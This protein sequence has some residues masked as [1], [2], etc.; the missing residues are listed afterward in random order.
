MLDL[1]IRGGTVID[2]TGA[3]RFQADIGI[4]GGQIVT[5]GETD[6]QADHEIDAQGLLVTPGWVDVH[7]HYDGQVTWDPYLTPSIWHGV[8]TVVMG[9][10]GVGFAPAAPDQHDWLISLMEGVEDI[11]GTA[12][13]EGIQWQ[14]ESFPEYM[15]SIERGSISIDV[16]AQVP[17]GALRAFVMGERGADHQTEPTTEEIETM[18]RLAREAIAA[19]AVGFSSSRTRN[20]RTKDGDYT[21]SLTASPAEMLGIAKA[22]GEGGRGVFEMVADFAHLD[23]E[24]ALLREMVEVSGRPMSISVAQN[25][26]VPNQWRRLLDLIGEAVNEGLPMTAQV[27]PR[28]IGLLLGLQASFHPFMTSRHYKGIEALPLSERVERMRDPSLKAKILADEI[29]PGLAELTCRFERIF[30]LGDPPDYEPAPEDSM[31]ARAE[32]DDITPRDLV[33]DLLLKNEGHALLYRTFLNYTDYNLDVSRDM[34]LDPNTVPG[35]GDAGA[36]CGLICD[37]SFPSFLMLHFGRDR[38]RGEKL[39]LEWLVKRQTAD[40][41]RLIG[42]EDRG[43]IQPGKRADL[44]LIDWSAMQLRPPEILFDLPAGGKRLV[45]RVD[46]YRMTL[47]AGQSVCEDGKPTGI[48]PGQLVRHASAS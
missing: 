45:Q 9:N 46:G 36:H 18:G 33:Y 23:E 44:N 34:L 40:T 14:W 38:T 15:D 30:E 39:E 11:P 37:G 21:P 22:I 10:C 12:L 24:F 26:R 20:H 42:L 8:T 2:G 4:R 6:E 25:D 28:A 43:V 5:V 41:A 32:A 7:T 27:P 48:L 13:A 3:P 16:V 17:H 47:V 31:T 29:S 19:G 1:I 35:L